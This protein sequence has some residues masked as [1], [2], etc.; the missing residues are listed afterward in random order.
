[1]SK[2]SAP[3]V[4]NRVRLIHNDPI[5]HYHLRVC[6]WKIVKCMHLN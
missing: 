6:T 1:M 3:E 4:M 5:H 2:Y